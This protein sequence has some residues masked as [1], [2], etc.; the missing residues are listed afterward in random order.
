ML[1][2]M[3]CCKSAGEEQA[4][5]GHKLECV[6]VPV[7]QVDHRITVNLICRPGGYRGAKALPYSIDLYLGVG[8][9]PFDINRVG[10]HFHRRLSIVGSDKVSTKEKKMETQGVGGTK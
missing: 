8:R 10:R 3:A 1:G 2:V 7:V 4:Q 5:R 6:R 9:P